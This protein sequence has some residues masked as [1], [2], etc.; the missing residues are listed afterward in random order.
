MKIRFLFILTI[1]CLVSSS[2]FA[3]S[4]LQKKVQ[5]EFGPEAVNL[6]QV[7]ILLKSGQIRMIP[8]RFLTES[9]CVW[10]AK[11]NLKDAKADAVRAF[12]SHGN[13]KKE[14]TVADLKK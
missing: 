11:A 3:Q 6:C 1:A 13:F 9:E 14:I 2:A 4:R 10:A 5:A 8:S 12:L 7:G